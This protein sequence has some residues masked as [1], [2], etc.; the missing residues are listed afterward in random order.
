MAARVQCGCGATY[1]LKDE[2]AGRTVK[3]PRCGAAIQVPAA[4]SPAV[5]PAFERNVFLLRQKH[6]ALTA[7]K[8]VVFAEDGAPIIYVKRPYHHLRTALAALA[9]FAAGVVTLVVVIVLA[10]AVGNDIALAVG[11]PV[12]LVGAV[13]VAIAVGVP[14]SVKRHVTFCLD[15]EGQNAVL[16]VIQHEKIYFLKANYTV[17]D[18]EGRPVALLRKKYIYD[19]FRKRWDCFRPDGSLWCVVREDSFILS[20][21]RRFLGPLFGALRTNFIFTD[22]AS[23]DVLGEFNRKFTILDRYVLDMTADPSRTIDRRVA[24]AIGVMLD[25]GEKR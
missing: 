8:Y 7:E 1:D 22:P 23:G 14:L 19:I 24:L 9:G 10:V 2:Y 17:T 4:S 5:Q 6:L 3:C 13:V 12:G 21:M 25:T 16:T 20:L 11:V 15:E 18:G